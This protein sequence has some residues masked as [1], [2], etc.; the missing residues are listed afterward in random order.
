MDPLLQGVEVGRS[1]DYHDDLPIH[2]G[3]LGKLLERRLELGEVSEQWLLVPTVQPHPGWG[4]GERSEAVP[5]RLIDEIARRPLLG[6]PGLHCFHRGLEGVT[7]VP[8]II[9]R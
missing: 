6:D 5:L 8:T 2:H 9:C 3:P 1:T 7:H 4:P